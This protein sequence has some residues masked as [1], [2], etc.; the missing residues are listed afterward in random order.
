MG[1]ACGRVIRLQ[2]IYS[3]LLFHDI[4]LPVLDVYG[5]YFTLLY[6]FWTNLLTGGPA[7]IAIFCLF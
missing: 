6:H 7:H 2:R 5:L 1:I 3:F 4:I